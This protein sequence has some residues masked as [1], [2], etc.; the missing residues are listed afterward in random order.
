MSR[1][2]VVSRKQW[3]LGA[4]AVVAV[5]VAAAF[6]RYETLRTERETQAAVQAVRVI[7]MVTGEFKTKLENGQEMEVYR[8]DPGT[9]FANDGERVELRIRGVNGNQHDFV[10]EGLNLRGKVEK[11]KETVVS[12]TA[13][14]GIYRIVCLTHSDASHAGPMIGYIVVD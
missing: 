7:H 12:F 10:I 8:F 2:W 3:R 1:F 5:M 4:I 14:E 13:K 9:V 6:W 11:N